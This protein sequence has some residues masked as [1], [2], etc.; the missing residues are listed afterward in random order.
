M[1]QSRASGRSPPAA[2][3]AAGPPRLRLLGLPRAEAQGTELRFPD[4]KCVA[5][6]AVLALDGPC[7]RARLADLL[8]DAGGDARRN[9]RRELHRLR[10][11]G[12]EGFVV[13]Q[14]D[15]L[16]L[17]GSVQVD[18]AEF[19]A[20]CAADPERA[21]ALHGGTLL[22][23]FDLA[24][25]EP[26][27]DWLAAHRHALDSRWRAAAEARA[28]TLEAGGDLRAALEVARRLLEADTLQEAPYRRA[29]RLH[30][31]LGEREAALALYERCR[32]VLGRE[33]GLKPL[34]ETVALADAVRTGSLAQP[35]APAAP[36]PALSPLQTLAGSAPIV[37]R[38]A[39]VTRLDAA[40]A[41]RLTLL[42]GAAGIGKTALLG[43]LAARRPGLV[44]LETRLSD[45]RVPYAALARWLRGAAGVPMPGWVQP[46]L[47]RLLPESGAAPAP[48]ESDS[49]RLR[50]FAAVGEAWRLAFGPAPAF[51]FDD[52]Q[53][54]D[55]AS[56]QWWGWWFGQGESRVLVAE[57]PG[58]AGALAAATLQDAAQ[59]QAVA[60]LDVPPLD[61][62]AMLELVARLSG[63]ASPR[64]F[65]HRLWQATGGHAFYA[66]QTLQHLLQTE[67]I[68]VDARGLWNTPYD[69]ATRDYHELPIAPSVQAAVLQRLRT[70][71]EATQRL[72]EAASLADDDFGLELLAR[73]SA[74]GEWE[75]VRS[76]EVALHARVLLRVGMEAGPHA[77]PGR[78]RFEHDLFS[79]AVAAS[80]SPERRALLHRLL[81][82][83]LA[84]EGADAA[85]VA[86]HYD[87]AG[88]ASGALAWHCR[89]LQRARQRTLPSDV[90]A[91]AE[92]VL[93]LAP[94]AE[95]RM[96][97]HLA[98][99]VALR[100]RADPAGA[101][102][103]LEDARAA[104]GPHAPLPQRVDLM[105]LQ[106]IEAQRD[107]RMAELLPALE[108]L[109]GEPALAPED[110]ARLLMR[111]GAAARAQ[112]R[113]EAALADQEAAIA[114]LGDE[115]G[116]LLAQ[117][118][119]NLARAAISAGRLDD[120]R[121]HA[122]RCAEVAR[123]AESP[124]LESG[125]L[126]LTGV[127]EKLNGRLEA[128]LPWLL[129][130]RE[131]AQRHGLVASERAA[132]LNL[133]SAWLA[134]G[135][136]AQ[137][138][139]AAD[140]GWAL[141][142]LFS[143]LSEQ[144]GFIEARYQCR[145][146]SG[147][148]GAALLA[149]PELLAASLKAVDHDRRA[150]GLLV[151]LDLPLTL[152]DAEGARSAA[153]ALVGLCPPGSVYATLAHAKR[154]WWAVVAG[155]PALAQAEL[156][157]AR[158]QPLQR[159]EPQAYLRLAAL[160]AAQAAGDTAAAAAVSV[161]LTD[162]GISTE[163][164]AQL[165]AAALAGPESGRWREPA[166]R[167]LATGRLPPLP[168]LLL[169][170]ALGDGEAAR[171]LAAPLQAS[172][173]GHAHERGLFERRFARWL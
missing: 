74:L 119:E 64:R 61:E 166:Q 173:A 54:V 83:A 69:D 22:Q 77:A 58:E 160:T 172:L 162:A 80:L 89:A 154:A 134:L 57:R 36:P 25:A 44:L 50:F 92:R 98:R 30:A 167:A 158:A 97:A 95:Q 132:I 53:F 86:A 1:V 171:A 109:L 137:A 62:P 152:H 73:A 105:S 123:A 8:W 130:A 31:A 133:V 155:Q 14:G 163:L 114:L 29:M 48:I 125:A 59:G 107:G 12:F 127:A 75:A 5:I 87:A 4:R 15:T 104:L 108:A 117:A 84:A 13:T 115:P 81:A 26:F 6:A 144:Q 40:L 78:Y 82:Q 91:H 151:S 2:A 42:R 41:G 112:G 101:R 131:V 43:A 60:V 169:A 90:L 51:V 35:A 67:V 170:D 17:H 124:A 79:Q 94:S 106:V 63:S 149:R 20:A 28:A 21:L 153:E 7:T 159:P 113:L 38:E 146:D 47:A 27:N 145:V 122:E 55:D 56:A 140:Q 118:L 147:E 157:A 168:A 18:A 121:R 24:G 9:L 45:R 164:W 16:S 23:G 139:E 161:D 156:A 129:R 126:M 65:A 128:S 32:R 136:P 116:H 111:R 93:A 141:S 102:A 52:W 85:R 49:Q 110:R 46:E 66:L 76:L 143:S 33:L 71:D 150:S 10:E 138:L 142:P 70:L 39:L 165:L 103:A 120:C 34:A 99:A 68:R 11:S 100:L 148:L 72:L 135:R 37:G 19:R 3:G 88:D 96:Q